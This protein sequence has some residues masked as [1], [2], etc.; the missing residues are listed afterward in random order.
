MF[1]VTTLLSKTVLEYRKSI[2]GVGEA[3]KLKGTKEP[4][5]PFDFNIIPLK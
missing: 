2:E 4:S 1:S 3:A 5:V